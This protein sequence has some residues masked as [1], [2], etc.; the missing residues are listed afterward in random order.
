MG[1]LRRLGCAIVV[2]GICLAVFF[3]RGL[4]LPKI[5]GRSASDS[6]SGAA[7]TWQ[8]LT[9]EGAS[10]A[11]LALRRLA[12]PNGPLFATVQPADLAA[13]IFQ[14][15]SRTLPTS[16]DSIE[17][18][19]IG[20]RLYVRALLRTSELGAKEALGP[21]SALLGERE[22]VQMGGT[23][24]IIRP[25]LGEFQVKE[26]KIRDFT[27]PSGVIPRLIRQLSRGERPAELAAD[28]L[29]L[30][31]PDYVGDVRVSSGR[32]T[33]YKAVPGQPLSI[34]NATKSPDRR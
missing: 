8:P 6:A 21:L 25:A 28:G 9:A 26:F 16:A 19:A 32:I 15:L 27:L 22:R 29:A 5:T 13:Y 31:T 11:R 17:A 10:R 7:G 12:T 33:M 34:P 23:L 30:R 24:R 20:D 4:W 18:A 2:I 3:T 1:L 14:E